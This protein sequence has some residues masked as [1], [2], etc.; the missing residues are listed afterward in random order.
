[1]ISRYTRKEMAEVWSGEKRFSWWLEIEILLLE[2][3]ASKGKI[4]PEVPRKVRE[5]AQI[6]IKRIRE[7]EKV[8]RHEVI[9]F[10]ESIIEQVGEEG[11]FIHFGLTSSDL[12]DTALSC[13]IQEGGKL[14]LQ[15]MDRLEN[16][17]REKAIQYKNLPM[18]GRTHGIHAEPITLGLKFAR[19]WE[20]SKRNRERLSQSLENARYGKISG[21]VGTYSHLEP[22]GEEFI[23]SRLGLKVEPVSSQIL[24]R[25][26]FA[27]VL[28][29][30]SLIATSL[31]EFSLEIRH[32]QRSEVGELEEPF[33]RGQKG[34][35]AMPHKRNPILS[36]RIC[37][38]AR[39]LRGNALVSLEN[40]PLWHERDISHSS[41][42]RIIVP[43]SFIL[44]DYL[45]DK[46][47]WIM[48]NLRVNE[49]KIAENMESCRGIY[50]SQNLML[51]LVDKGMGRVEAYET[52]QK[53]A[54]ESMEKG[55]SFLE[56][57]KKSSEIREIF[58]EQEVEEIFSLQNLL[59]NVDYIFDRI[60]IYE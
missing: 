60:G 49:I 50:F 14:L 26:R 42:E 54:M 19:W 41:A 1:M 51:K 36:E 30:I 24:P 57:V 34:S 11:K 2:Y 27:E 33:T 59:A 47:T 48:E 37:G 43:D 35:S 12:M 58:T 10:V 22:E 21:A 39:V 29:T 3:L 5:K 25:D 56:R 20:E 40:V 46:F 9:A 31:E 17:L 45:L 7:L 8:N 32:L 52:V 53:L 15:D 13:Q 44:L 23:L 18:I 6:D 28:L 16:A 4:L 55:Q 38:L